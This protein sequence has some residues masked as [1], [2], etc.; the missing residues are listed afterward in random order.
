MSVEDMFIPLLCCSPTSGGAARL[1]AARS[2][3]ARG[4]LVG[5][6]DF[7]G[8][9]PEWV[10]PIETDYRGNTVRV[11][12]PNSYGLMM[13]MQLNALSGLSSDELAGDD[14]DRLGYQMRAMRAAFAEEKGDQATLAGGHGSAC[15][16]EVLG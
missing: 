8:Y 1:R 16:S 6:A 7:E 11:M 14:A 13:L 12:P 3:P 10:E 15:G 4:G 2:R 5:A 9:Q